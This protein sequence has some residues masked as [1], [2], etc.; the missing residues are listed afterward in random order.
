MFGWNFEKSTFA[1]RQSSKIKK[2]T[3][4]PICYR[5]KNM[6]HRSAWKKGTLFFPGCLF[7]SLL[8]CTQLCTLQS[9]MSTVAFK[10]TWPL[11]IR[12]AKHPTF[13]PPQ[14]TL[15]VTG[16]WIENSLKFDN[17]ALVSV[18]T[19][20]IV[21]Y[22]PLLSPCFCTVCSWPPPP[23]PTVHWAYFQPGNPTYQKRLCGP[24][25]IVCVTNRH[26]HTRTRKHATSSHMAHMLPTTTH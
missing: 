2:K 10:Q 16:G 6:T 19:H 24:A 26:L 5:G 23:H 13:S 21:P 4:I 11:S 14:K 3:Q 15:S 7:S 22:S 1:N 17:S 9:H 8:V 20:L 12:H 18:N 25:C